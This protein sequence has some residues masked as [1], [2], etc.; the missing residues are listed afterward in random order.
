L[1]ITV[2]RFFATLS[3]FGIFIA[4]MVVGQL[5][6]PFNIWLYALYVMIYTAAVFMVGI[7]AGQRSEKAW[8]LKR[9]AFSSMESQK[10]VS[11]SRE[12]GNIAEHR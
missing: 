9:E 4:G 3:I 11:D 12:V 10:E 5:Y 7:Y 1:V 8:T 2:K 6:A